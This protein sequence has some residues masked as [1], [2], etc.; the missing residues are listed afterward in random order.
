[1][2]DKIEKLIITHIKFR[3]SF[4]EVPTAFTRAFVRKGKRYTFLGMEGTIRDHL[5][6]TAEKIRNITSSST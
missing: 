3:E 4:T 1:M 2:Q 5:Q 6:K